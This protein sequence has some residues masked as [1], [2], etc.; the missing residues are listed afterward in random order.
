MIPR[1]KFVLHRQL[2]LIARIQFEL[3]KLPRSFVKLLSEQIELHRR[4]TGVRLGFEQLVVRR[5]QI[6]LQRGL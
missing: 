1:K 3:S 6:A 4:F 5:F 2:L